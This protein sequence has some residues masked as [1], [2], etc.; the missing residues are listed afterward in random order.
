MGDVTITS[1]KIL[2][3]L[4]DIVINLVEVN[5]E[6]VYKP[7]GIIIPKFGGG[8]YKSG[9]YHRII[10]N[11]I[12]ILIEIVIRLGVVRIILRVIRINLREVNF[13]ISD[14]VV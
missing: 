2:S 6:R 12:T 3:D 10:G 4:R 8:L 11:V 1:N 13:R 5:L 7:A 14:V 9:T